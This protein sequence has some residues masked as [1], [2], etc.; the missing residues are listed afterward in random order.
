VARVGTA[1]YASELT[2]QVADLPPPYTWILPPPPPA[3]GR[4]ALI[5]GIASVPLSICGIGAVLGILAV[6]ASRGGTRGGVSPALIGRVFGILGIAL[7]IGAVAA[8]IYARN[9]ELGP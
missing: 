3:S 6:F 9:S 8:L 1:T 5:L 2:D 7:S 4:V